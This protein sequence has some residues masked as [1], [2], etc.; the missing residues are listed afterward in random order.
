MLLLKEYCFNAFQQ[1]YKIILI[2]NNTN[3]LQINY[4]DIYFMTMFKDQNN[5]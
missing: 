1:L 2:E 4:L 3:A 5:N